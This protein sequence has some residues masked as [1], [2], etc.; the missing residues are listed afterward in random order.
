VTL[1][2]RLEVGRRDF[3]V[4]VDLHTATETLVVVGPS[5]CGKT[6]VLRTLAG[7]LTPAAGRITLDE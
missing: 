1:Q 5:G 7:L 6:T 4:E 2:A 3:T